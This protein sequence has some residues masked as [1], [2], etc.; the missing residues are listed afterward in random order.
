MVDG[1]LV[2]SDDTGNIKL[3]HNQTIVIDNLTVGWKVTATEKFGEGVTDRDGYAVTW[4]QT[5]NSQKSDDIGRDV[6]SEEIINSDGNA[7]TFTNS[8]GTV[9]DT[10]LTTDNTAFWALITAA[11]LL[12]LAILA[13][14][15]HRYKRTHAR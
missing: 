7:I 3:G 5:E 2:K 15:V 11:G 13:I 12:A 10:N 4:T 9:P 8:K 14:S 1:K 6:D